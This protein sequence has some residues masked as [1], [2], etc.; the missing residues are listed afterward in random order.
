[1]MGDIFKDELAQLER[2]LAQKGVNK[3]HELIMDLDEDNP[4]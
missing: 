1:M 2:K 3:L 4:G